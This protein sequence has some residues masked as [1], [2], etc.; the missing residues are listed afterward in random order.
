LQHDDRSIGTQLRQYRERA[1]LTQEVL[2]E[3]AGLIADAIG[4][5]E[6]SVRQRPY[7]HTVTALAQALQ[8]STAERRPD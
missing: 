7:P 8:V 6:S 5:L 2:A 3:R 1:G 4:A